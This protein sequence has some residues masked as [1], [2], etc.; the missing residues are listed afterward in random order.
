[1]IWLALEVK[2]EFK[3]EEEKE[4]IVLS[5]LEGEVEFKEEEEDLQVIW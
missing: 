4:D 2:V 1:M 5:V 3:E